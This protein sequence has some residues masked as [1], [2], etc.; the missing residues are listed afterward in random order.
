METRTITI[1][2]NPISGVRHDKKQ[3]AE[4]I[5]RRAKTYGFDSV[6]CYTQGRGDATGIARQAVE[7]NHAMVVVLGG[8]GTVNEA[9]SGLLNSQVSLGIVPLGSGNGLART[10]SIPTKVEKACDVLFEGKAVLADAGR[11]NDRLF[12]LVVG[13]GF[14]AA[15][16][17]GFDNFHRR[18]FLS[19]FYVGLR[20]FFNYV[21]CELH[22]SFAEKNIN[23]RPFMVAVANGQQYGNNALIAPHAQ[24]NDGKFDLVVVNRFTIWQALTQFYKI[25]IGRIRDFE[26]VDFYRADKI[27]IERAAAGIVNVDG[28]ACQL[29]ATLDISIIPKALKVV[30]PPNATCFC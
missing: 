20:E 16:S 3:L 26:E 19:Y 15:V 21:P 30:V 6:I 10:L 22:I 7:N 29:E 25:F 24:I 23:S 2:A 9:A 18:G 28:E 27:R 5:A 13:I 12:F 8:D 11:V 17:E 1:L 14:D 4:E